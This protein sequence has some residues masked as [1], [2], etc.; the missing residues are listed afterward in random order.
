MSFLLDTD[1]CSAHVKGNYRIHTRFIQ[2]GGRLHVS[3]VTLGKLWAWVRRAKAPPRRLQALREL[4][5]QV[6]VLPFDETCQ[7]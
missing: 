1:I 6:E 3:T 2:Y 7:G 5:K 4:L